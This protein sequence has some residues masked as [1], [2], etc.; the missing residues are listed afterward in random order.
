MVGHR[1]PEML[2]LIVSGEALVL[3]LSPCLLQNQGQISRECLGE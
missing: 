1:E 2:L 3:F